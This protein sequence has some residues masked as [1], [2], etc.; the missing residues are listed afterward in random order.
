M[1]HQWVPIPELWGVSAD[2]QLLSKMGMTKDLKFHA[3]D[4]AGVMRRLEHGLFYLVFINKCF[5][6]SSIYMHMTFELFVAF[7]ISVD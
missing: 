3:A 1:R 4:N 2:S 5:Y 7:Y 6:L